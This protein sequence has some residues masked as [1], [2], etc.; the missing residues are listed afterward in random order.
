MAAS[1]VADG[2]AVGELAAV[3]GNAVPGAPTARQ[4]D[5]L[6]NTESDAA[7]EPA[8]ALVVGPVTDAA[9]A[10][11]ADGPTAV[12]LTLGQLLRRMLRLLSRPDEVSSVQRA[13]H[14]YTESTR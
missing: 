14:V 10:E 8:N 7:A 1:A 9:V 11:G 2:A 6:V 12:C 3:A 13:Q 4:P 5:A